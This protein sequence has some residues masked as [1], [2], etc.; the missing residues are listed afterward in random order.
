MKYFV[1]IL[2]LCLVATF[3]VGQASLGTVSNVTALSACPAGFPAGAQCSRATVSCAGDAT[4]TATYGVHAVDNPKGT[5]VL[6]YGSGG[7]APFPSKYDRSLTNDGYTVITLAWSTGWMQTGTTTANLKTAACRPATLI[8]YLLTQVVTSGARCALGFSGGSGALGYSLAEYGASSYL[9][10]VTFESGPV[11]SDISEGCK[12]PHATDV[13]VC[14]AGQFGCVPGDTFMDDPE[15]VGPTAS[16]MGRATGDMSCAGKKTTTTKS[17]N[18]W[19]AQSIVDA[20]S[21]S[22]FSYPSTSMSGFICDNGVNNSAAEGSLFYDQ[23]TSDSQAY[24]FTVTPIKNCNGPEGVDYG[25]TP[26]GENGFNAI[27]ADMTEPING[28][29]EHTH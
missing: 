23:F 1:G 26:S 8:N 4:I 24:S 9:D 28:C 20:Q 7:T 29:V 15:Y 27:I 19:K 14:P 21:D 22:M 11:F 25:T 3:A 16:G 2:C 13:Q 18:A 12:V 17:A 10:K 6:H 5:I